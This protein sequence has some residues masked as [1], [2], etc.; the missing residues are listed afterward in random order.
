MQKKADYI[1]IGAGVLGSSL[2]YYLTKKGRDV[3]VLERGEICDGVSST[4]AALVLPSP[5]TPAVYNQLAWKGYE[6][7]LALEEELG[8]D[9]G[10]Q[11]TGSTMLCWAPEKTD[12]ND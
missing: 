7:F 10:L 9:I 8:A 4:T 6:R 3:I 5:K 12:G 1:I 11:I 2:A